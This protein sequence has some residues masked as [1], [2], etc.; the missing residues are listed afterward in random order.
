M[1]PAAIVKR[2]SLADTVSAIGIL[3]PSSLVQIDTRVSAQLMK[4]HV[5][6]RDSV[7]AGDLIAE[8]DSFEQ[9]NRMRVARALLSQKQ[10][11]QRLAQFELDRAERALGRQRQLSASQVVSS[12][13]LQDAEVAAGIAS[14]KL[15]ESTA[16]VEEAAAGV[17][18]A[19]KDLDSTQ[20][21]APIDGRVIALEPKGE[22]PQ[23]SRVIAVIGQ[24]DVMRARVQVSEADVARVK[25]GQPVHFTTAGDRKTNRASVVMEVEPAPST[26]L[27]NRGPPGSGCSG[28][29]QAVCY[30]V[31]FEA[32][33]TDGKLLPMMTAEVTIT[34]SAVDNVL[35]APRGALVGPDPQGLYYAKVEKGDGATESR[36][37][38][39][40]LVNQTHAEIVAGLA[41]GE[42][43]I[44][45]KD[46][47][48]TDTD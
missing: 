26:L 5:S 18:K 17:A 14:A 34:V 10:A 4:F 40:G 6:L 48:I 47:G 35:L 29:P 27:T 21:T 45:Q 19:Q 24:T 41:E 1:A 23:T 12:A 33:N 2:G 46:S 39:V 30:N 37:V 8:M 42:K 38:R 43:I 36:R 44:L 22:Q 28:G 3:E 16:K 20:I 25:V 11:A 7:H 32:P 13:A 15:E 31:V 9:Q